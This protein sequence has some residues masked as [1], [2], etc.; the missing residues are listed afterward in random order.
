MYEVNMELGGSSD[1]YWAMLRFEDRKGKL[2]KK[3]FKKERR[4]DKNTNVLQAVLEAFQ[5]LRVPC[6]VHLFTEAGHVLEP[7]RNGW[8]AKWEAKGWKNSEGKPVKNAELWKRLS[9]ELAWHQI[10]LH[11]AKERLEEE[12]G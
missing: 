5:I 9:I 10:T 12:T 1:G 3:E 4:A 2:H 8:L 11:D 6:E 7:M